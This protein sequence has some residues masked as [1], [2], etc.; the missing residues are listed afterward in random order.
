MKKTTSLCCA[1][2]CLLS[3]VMSSCG[4]TDVQQPTSQET[5]GGS[6]YAE[7][8]GGS[9]ETTIDSAY[10][11]NL[12]AS[13]DFGGRT[14]NFLLYGDGVPENWSEIDVLAEEDSAETID[15]GIYQR[16]LALE[17]RLNIK[18]AGEYSMQATKEINK[19]VQAGDPTYDAVWLR[20]SEAGPAAQNNAL[21]DWKD[22]PNIDLS[23]LYWDQSIIR[24]LSVG[25][26]VYFLTGDISTIDNQA[27][28]IMMFNKKMIADN[29]LTSPYELVSQGRWTIDTFAEMTKNVAADI[30]GDGK[31]TMQ[32]KYG[33]STTPDTIYGLFYST[34]LTFISKDAD[35]MP[36]FSLNVEKGTEVLGKIGQIMNHDNRTLL[37]TNIVKETSDVITGV[38]TAFFENRAL[39]YA[40]VMFHVANLRQMETDFGII[41]LPKYDEAQEHYITFVNPAGSCLAVPTTN[42]KPQETGIIL[43]AMASASYQYL[44][45][46]YYDTAL[47]GKY[48][49]DNES[50][51]MLDLLLQNRAYDLALIYNWGNLAPGY[52]QLAQKDSTDLSSMVAKQEKK[53]NTD[54]QKFIDGFT[55]IS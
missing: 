37:T 38:R 28:W 46:A 44:T 55:D 45:P 34:G 18:I 9:A 33:L 29:D 53:L 40:E 26:R 5:T 51:D 22:I 31:Y 54:L 14:F 32:D 24:D 7:T 41:P 12:D 4:D 2:F 19:L 36:R 49:R 43:E 52:V 10:V 23:K 30:D 47:K 50:A 6:T 15:H 27:T 48:A 1:M 17:E 21:Y 20:L 8:T 11:D 3:V 13:Y 42:A 25:G 35:D 16:N 39:F